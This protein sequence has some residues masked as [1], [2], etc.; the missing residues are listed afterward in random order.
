M[1]E[2]RFKKFIT[3][4]YGFVNAIIPEKENKAQGIYYFGV[5][6]KLPNNLITWV[7]DSGVARRC[8]GKVSTYIEANGFVNKDAGSKIVGTDGAT[9]NDLLSDIATSL[10]YFEGFALHIKRDGF[11]NVKAIKSIP[12]QCVRRTNNGEFEVNLTYGQ[13]KFD[14]NKTK[15]YPAFK[16]RLTEIEFLKEVK[17][18]GDGEILYAYISSPDNS[19]YP[20]P[21]YYSQIEDIR[22]SS[23]LAKFDYETVTNGFITSAVLTYIGELDGTQKD[24]AGKTE[25]DYFQE[26]LKKFSGQTKDQ[27]GLSGRNKLL[28]LNTKS[29]EQA[30]T[31]QPFDSKAI[32]EASN[33]KRDLIERAVCRLFGVPPVLAGFS[34]AAILGNTQSI[35]NASLELNKNVQ[36]LQNL[37]SKTF[38]KL[39]PE[40]DWTLTEYTPVQYIEPGLYQYMTN[41]EIRMKLLNLSPLNN[42]TNGGA[43][44]Q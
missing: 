5:D 21:Q 10:A 2:N 34:D 14:K 7:N 43:T 20:N 18:I 40:F 37:I 30:P 31:L 6:N 19:Y 36:P 41:D 17:N 23:E 44:N 13:Q 29:A 3:G 26:G 28:V 15:I 9:A 11:G 32:F 39:W 35:A 33:S 8:V 16:G 27:Y 1:N 25:V 4:V 38:K 42:T 12:F 24:E 22:T